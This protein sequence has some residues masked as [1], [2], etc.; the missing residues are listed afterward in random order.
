VVEGPWLPSNNVCGSEEPTGTSRPWSLC[1]PVRGIYTE[2]SD[3]RVAPPSAF[4][5]LAAAPPDLTVEAP[6]A[7]SALPATK[8]EEGSVGVDSPRLV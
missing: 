7:I 4:I 5:P 2:R 8:R 6:N 1:Q 3:D